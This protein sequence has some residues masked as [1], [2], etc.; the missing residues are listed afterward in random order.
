MTV[1]KDIGTYPSICII[2]KFSAKQQFSEYKYI[3]ADQIVLFSSITR[4][5]L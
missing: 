3:Q 4:G 1:M 2:I 5:I